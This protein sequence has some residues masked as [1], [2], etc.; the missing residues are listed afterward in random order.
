MARCITF[1]ALDILSGKA[2]LHLLTEENTQ[3][4]RCTM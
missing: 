4:D 2:S 3:S 1:G